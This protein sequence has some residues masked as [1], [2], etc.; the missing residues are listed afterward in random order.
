MEGGTQGGLRLA[1]GHRQV[2][3]RGMCDFAKLLANP[4]PAKFYLYVCACVCLCSTCQLCL[5]LCDP[6]DCSPLDFSVPGIFQA[7]ILERVAISSSRGSSPS[8]D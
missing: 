8:R 6:M 5:T 3:T 1:E 2:D 4:K 7:R